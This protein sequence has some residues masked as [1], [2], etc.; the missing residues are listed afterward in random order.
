[1]T[2]E[3]KNNIPLL[4]ANLTKRGP[5]G[6]KKAALLL[7]GKIVERIESNIPPPL[8]RSTIEKKGS[9]LALV[10][11]GELLGE[12]T[13]KFPDENS[14]QVGIW[15]EKAKIGIIHEWGAPRAGIPERS[16][17]RATV[18]NSKNREEANAIMVV[19]LRKA[20]EESNVK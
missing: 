9:S 13:H 20:F 1:M 4:I 2:T 8:A 11:K 10:D 16:F 17:M 6:V 14:A 12:V 5:E 7:E 3:I 19:A 18:N 15:G